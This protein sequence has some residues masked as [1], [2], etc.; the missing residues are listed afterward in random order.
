M[1]APASTEI[2]IVRKSGQED[3]VAQM[4]VKNKVRKITSHAVQAWPVRN[5]GGAL[6]LVHDKKAKQY[7]LR[8]Y[9]LGSGRRRVLGAVE[10]SA[11]TIHESHPDDEAWA[12]ALSGKDL[13]TG[14]PITIVGDEQAIP[15]RHP[16][17][18]ITLLQQ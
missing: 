11:G 3:G 6:I 14:K 2:T 4:I 9:D 16:R 15:R 7:F 1:E 5:G 17:G 18:H 8:Y 13:T 10:L 12:F